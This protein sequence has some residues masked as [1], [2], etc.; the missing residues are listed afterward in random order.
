MKVSNAV[1]FYFKILHY[2]FFFNC[3]RIC[4]ENNELQK[5]CRSVTGVDR[6]TMT[7]S[8][9]RPGMMAFSNGDRVGG[10]TLSKNPN[11]LFVLRDPSCCYVD[12]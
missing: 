6:M 1:F 2:V 8:G 5:C 11:L 7:E 4:P 3:E 10:D 9:R 12:I